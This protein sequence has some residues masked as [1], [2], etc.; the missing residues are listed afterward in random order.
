[1]ISVILCD[2]SAS[3]DF[4]RVQQPSSSAK[5]IEARLCSVDGDTDHVG[6]HWISVIVIKTPVPASLRTIS[7]SCGLEN[8]NKITICA[9]IRRNVIRGSPLVF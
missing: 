1:M 9:L 5:L 4:K 7:I 3:V 2:P 6:R 8:N